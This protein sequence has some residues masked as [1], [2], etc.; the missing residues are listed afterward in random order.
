MA[1]TAPLVYLIGASGAGKDTVLDAARAEFEG[2]DQVVFARRHITRPAASGGERHVAVDSA[3]FTA[4]SEAGSFLLHWRGNRLRY[5]IHR[6]YGDALAAGRV[7]VVNGSRAYL[8]EA[9]RH[10]P[11]LVP[12][13][14]RVDPDILRQR[15]L[16]RAR[17][18]ENIIEERLRR[19]RRL[20]SRVPAD[21]TVIDN[22]GDIGRAVDRF[23]QLLRELSRERTVSAG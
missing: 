5:G 20:Q 4:L 2:D 15:L 11:S 1:A 19:A 21:A 18:T 17:E 3:T 7:V 14:L 23:C 22:S 12:V 10:C 13:V 9:R 6:Q 16:A 8:A